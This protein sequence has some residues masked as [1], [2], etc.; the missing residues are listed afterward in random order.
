MFVGLGIGLFWVSLI[1]RPTHAVTTTCPGFAL[2]INN[3][4]AGITSVLSGPVPVTVTPSSSVNILKTIIMDNGAIIGRAQPASS[5]NWTMPWFTDAATN[6]GHAITA[7]V[8]LDGGLV[9]PAPVI[10]TYVNNPVRATI[11]PVVSPLKFAGMTNE[12]MDFNLANSITGRNTAGVI[13]V[14]NVTQYTVFKKMPP[15]I[16]IL[17]PADETERFRFS[18]GTVAGTGTINVIAYYGGL[19]LPM[20]IPATVYPQTNT[21]SGS[22]G[23]ST[24]STSTTSGSSTSGSTSP[25]SGTQDSITGANLL[26]TNPNILTQL[27]SAASIEASPQTKT[28]T[29]NAI[30]QQRYEEIKSGKSRPTAD[31]FELLNKCFA[32]RNFVLPTSFVPIPPAKVKE[33]PQNEDLVKI[34]NASN[35]TKK[36]GTSKITTLK[37]SGKAK[38]ES[39]VLIYVHSEPLVLSTTADKNGDWN[40]QLED[41]LE[42]GKHEVYAVVDK[43]NGN[44]QRS[45]LF[46]FVI[47][48]ASASPVNPKG[49]S[50]KIA[51]TRPTATQNNRSLNL[52]II[53][54]VALVVFVL[55]ALFVIIEVQHKKHKSLVY[56]GDQPAVPDHDQSQVPS[57]NQD[58]SSSP[59]ADTASEADVTTRAVP[60]PPNTMHPPN[61]GQPPTAEPQISTEHDNSHS[62]QPPNEV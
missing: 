4:Q 37:F 11:T 17:T 40:Y 15:A 61:T 39:I 3:N 13:G 48:K 26:P 5:N 53:A 50:L 6:G 25:T 19:Q 29:V 35:G 58:T 38:P 59:Q 14:T 2:S 45:G 27:S 24:G 44:Y 34:E 43:G 12:A 56:D 52:Y 7:Q 18:A 49:Y 62:Q 16:G 51:Q 31:E 47:A 22:S 54:S 32:D 23:G 41:P 21:S 28:C 30:S 55:A 20:A 60:Q 9:C 42:S 46:S 36:S 10:N 8:Y 1:N 57:N 33:L